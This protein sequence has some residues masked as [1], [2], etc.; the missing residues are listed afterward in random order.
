MHEPPA[1]LLILVVTCGV[2]WWAFEHPWAEEKCLFRPESILAGKEYYRLVSSGFVHSGLGHLL[3]NIYTLYAFGPVVSWKFNQVGFLLIY[4]GSIVGGNLLSL[5]L[6]RFHDYAAYGASGGVCGVIFAHVL[7]FPESRMVLF[8]LPYA[9]PGWLFAT[10]FIVASFYAMKVQ[11]DNFGHD[12]H[13]GGAIVGLLLA[14]ALQPV[15]VQKAWFTFL[16]ILLVSAAVLAYLWINP[17]GLPVSWLDLAPFPWKRSRPTSRSGRPPARRLPAGQRRSPLVESV[18][19]GDWLVAEIEEQIGP[20]RVD[21][22]GQH[23]WID[24]FGRTYDMLAPTAESFEFQGFQEAVLSK[25]D[26]P[27]VNFVIVDTRQLTEH[28]I[29]LVRPFIA[30]LPDVQFH[31]ILRSYAFKAPR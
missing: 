4:L 12:A 15:L 6:H 8:P 19:P 9:V 7:A 18:K 29:N 21:E 31:R 13:L 3:L 22:T 1:I 14:A 23:T 5:Y 2:S 24:K 10:A 25:L 17:L 28:Q 11:R 26:T 20:L 16:G 30:D 27:E